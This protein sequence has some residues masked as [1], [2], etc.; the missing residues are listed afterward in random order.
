MQTD[1]IKVADLEILIKYV[2]E[3]YSTL[4]K[5]SSQSNTPEVRHELALCSIFQQP[6]DQKSKSTNDVPRYTQSELDAISNY[7]NLTQ[8]V[9]VSGKESAHPDVSIIHQT[10]PHISSQTIGDVLNGINFKE[11][12]PLQKSILKMIFEETTQLQKREISFERIDPIDYADPLPTNIKTS[13]N[14]KEIPH[15]EI[16]RNDANSQVSARK[17]YHSLFSLYDPNYLPLNEHDFLCGNSQIDLINLHEVQCDI[18]IVELPQLKMKEGPTEKLSGVFAV[19][20]ANTSK[21]LTENYYME[22][23]VEKR[24]SPSDS[25]FFCISFDTEI[26]RRS[27][28]KLKFVLMVY[29]SAENDIFTAR[30]MYVK[31]DKKKKTPSDRDRDLSKKIGRYRQFLGI[32]IYDEGG[33]M[34][35]TDNFGEKELPIYREDI[36]KKADLDTFMKS[37]TKAKIMNLTWGFTMK[38]IIKKEE[39]I[40]MRQNSKLSEEISKIGND[41]KPQKLE[42]PATSKTI[43]NIKITEKSF[44]DDGKLEN[45]SPEKTSGSATSSVMSEF[46]ILDSTGNYLQNFGKTAETKKVVKILQFFPALENYKNFFIDFSHTVYISPNE[47]NL[48]SLTPKDRKRTKFLITCYFRCSDKEM[49]SSSCLSVFYSKTHEGK[50]SPSVSTTVSVSNSSN[51]ADY[52]IDEF[53]AKL[54]VNLTEQHHFFFVI[55]DVT[56]SFD[57]ARTEKSSNSEERRSEK[58]ERIEKKYFAYRPV[59][60]G[61]NLIDSS[62]HTLKVYTAKGMTGYMTSTDKV[63]DFLGDKKSSFKVSFNFESTLYP[64]NKYLYELLEKLSKKTEMKSIDTLLTMLYEVPVVEIAH[65]LPVIM[66]DILEFFR[67]KKEEIVNIRGTGTNERSETDERNDPSRV[68]TIFDTPTKSDNLRENIK[69]LE[70]A[71]FPFLFILKVIYALTR[72]E[73]NNS[74]TP[75]YRQR[76]HVLQQFVEFFFTNG[77]ISKFENNEGIEGK[78]ESV[79]V[80]QKL[81]AAMSTYFEK[82]ETICLSASTS[83]Q[84]A[85]NTLNDRDTTRHKLIN[86][87]IE[88]GWFFFSIITKS[89][90]LYLEENKIYDSPNRIERIRKLFTDPI[91]SDFNAN[92]IKV[93][94]HLANLVRRRVSETSPESYHVFFLNS[95]YALFNVE[96]CRFYDPSQA[97]ASFSLY[98]NVLSQ[99]L[100]VKTKTF[101]TPT[102]STTLQLPSID[103]L[104]YLPKRENFAACWQTANLLKVDFLRVIFSYQ[105]FFEMNIPI[106]MKSD[107]IKTVETLKIEINERHIFANFVVESI[108]SLLEMDEPVS[109][110]AKYSVLNLL[111]RIDEEKRYENKKE[112]AAQLFLTILIEIVRNYEYIETNWEKQKEGSLPFYMIIIWLL[113]SINLQLIK[114][115]FTIEES[116]KLLNFIRLL[117]NAKCVFETSIHLSTDPNEVITSKIAT[118]SEMSRNTQIKSFCEVFGVND[119]NREKLEEMSITKFKVQTRK[120]GI[121]KMPR[122]AEKVTKEKTQ[123]DE[124]DADRFVNF[125]FNK[126]EK[127]EKKPTE[128]SVFA[129]Y[130][131][132]GDGYLF[133]RNKT[134][135]KDNLIEDKDKASQKNQKM[136]NLLYDDVMLVILEITDC[137]FNAIFERNDEDE[138]KHICGFIEKLF[139]THPP[140]EYIKRFFQFIRKIV[141]TKIE[142]LFKTNLRFS[143][144][145]MKGIVLYC[146]SDD[147]DMRV[148]A[149]SVLYLFVNQILK[150]SKMWKRQRLKY[151]VP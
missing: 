118:L 39:R 121:V 23:P 53:K 146:N 57:D 114:K 51:K 134:R 149:T 27:G 97:L 115:Y 148:D 141:R 104:T 128:C 33:I 74:E 52:F 3:N 17:V 73:D 78:R 123:K 144:K 67:E 147:G 109:A 120:K 8:K 36:D 116:S 76:N 1:K 13:E 87:A 91:F 142:H 54:P 34:D 137:L 85:T 83:L 135:E 80:F 64:K 45:S 40:F 69:F 12:Q 15:I 100:D 20:D 62:E 29:K 65:F 89:L 38:K 72:E 30:D 79:P 19:Y 66:E 49:N 25:A 103:F 55:E 26:V 117:S 84:Q 35:S 9:V 6:S 108:L 101:F 31:D 133:L 150:C 77:Q 110:Y 124:R 131:G 75:N 46:A 140:K 127:T 99:M 18:W 44:L 7:I 98:L 92:L 138:L 71:D 151:W 102:D 43:R 32:G 4:I 112:E 63:E 48:V 16:L 59:F 106:S 126:G 28:S 122:M 96:L 37:E 21:K 86:V 111:C 81:M 5:K 42:I 10:K 2:E 139:V 132:L 61:G 47:L 56:S 90:V 22:F 58:G 129:P 82:L 136:K 94:R 105:Y 119:E 24:N 88:Y 125:L 93:S 145:L 41:A 113:K 60:E 14:Q 68:S 107:N 143:F 70:D 50:Y 11:L 130:P 95:D